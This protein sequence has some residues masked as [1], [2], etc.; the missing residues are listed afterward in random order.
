MLRGGRLIIKIK[1]FPN[2]PLSTEQQEQPEQDDTNSAEGRSLIGQDPPN[3]NITGYQ[4]K[5]AASHQRSFFGCLK[6]RVNT[7]HTRA[8]LHDPRA[9][10][11]IVALLTL[12]LYTY[13][14][15]RQSDAMHD[16]L[17]EVRRQTSYANI[18]A[19]A[20]TAAATAAQNAIAQSKDQFVK[21]QRPYI[22]V[23]SNKLGSPEFIP[24]GGDVNAPTGQIVW[25]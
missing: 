16:T 15:G 5:Y 6:D 8:L 20:A 25:T 24:H 10:I 22:W 19:S 7:H 2:K 13:F 3:Q 12:G 23:L 9:W 14:A 21:D 11:E 18:S 17:V 4:A 1:R